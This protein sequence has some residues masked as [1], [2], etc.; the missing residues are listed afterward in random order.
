MSIDESDTDTSEEM[1]VEVTPKQYSN[2]VEKLMHSHPEMNKK[3][4]VVKK[5]PTAV[6]MWKIDDQ[7]RMDQM[8][9][10]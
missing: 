4:N 6:D 8:S 3:V 9:D 2:F 1:E 7:R 10:K 5:R